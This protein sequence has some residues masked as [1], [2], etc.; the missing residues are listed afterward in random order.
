MSLIILANISGFPDPKVTWFHDDQEVRATEK[1][2]IE[3]D[4]R[5][6]RLTLTGT[7]GKTTGVYKLVAE[8]DI[9]SA[10]EVFDVTVLGEFWA[11]LDKQEEPRLLQH[12]VTTLLSFGSGG[13][14]LHQWTSRLS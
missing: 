3:G 9:G 2:T 1:I 10:E 11:T 7:T 12:I 8:N 4:N 6:S 5:F 14:W 13:N